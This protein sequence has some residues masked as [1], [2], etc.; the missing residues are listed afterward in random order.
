MK[1]YILIQE[2]AII[3]IQWRR[4]FNKPY[5]V[6]FFGGGGSWDPPWC[7]LEKTQKVLFELFD[8]SNLHMPLTLGSK[9]GFYTKF[10]DSQAYCLNALFYLNSTKSIFRPTSGYWIYTFYSSLERLEERIADCTI[11]ASIFDIFS[12]PWIQI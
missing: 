12:Y 8:F 2:S 6:F 4:L 5:S 3:S 10:L 1:I 9:R 11:F 7:F